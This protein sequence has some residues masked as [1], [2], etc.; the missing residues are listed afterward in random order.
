MATAVQ[1][2]VT[3]P[4]AMRNVVLNWAAFVFSVVVNF[5]ISPYIVHTLGNTAYGIWVLLASLVG[6]MG[7]LDLGV[8]GAVMRYVARHHA[9]SE[10]GEAGRV[11]SA[12]LVIFTA[13]GLLAL[14]ASAVIAVLIDRLFKI[15]ADIVTVARLVVLIGGVSVAASLIS[16]VFGGV[17]TALQRFDL[18][19][20]LS[21]AVGAV[22]ALGVVGALHAGWGLLG[23]AGVQLACTLLQAAGL[24][25]M[26]ARLYPEL[27]YRF[28]GL[29]KAVL[30]T[31]FSFSAYSSLLHVST[32]LMFSVDSVVIGAFL[33]LAMITFFS[34]GATLTDYARSLVSSISQTM[35]PRVSALEG[36]NAAAELEGVFR[37]AGA[38]ATLVTLPITIT[39][40]VRGA[41]FIGLWMGPSY[42]GPSGP[43][44]VI[45]SVALSFAAA[46]QVIVSAIMGVNRHRTLAP[47]YVAEGLINLGLSVYWAR[48]LGIQGVA[49][50]TAVPNLVTTFLVIPWLTRQVFG[51]RFRDLWA[52]MW[53][54]P[55]VAM[56]PF[57]A[58][59]Y[60]IERFWPAHGLVTFFAGVA[61]ALPAAAAGAW[62][63]GLESRTRSAYAASMRR[64]LS[65]VF[66][67][68]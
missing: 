20:I 22:R 11:A 41:S 47:F 43:V 29:G 52:G 21:I 15:P 23:L 36:L 4:R 60:A 49:L 68:A 35:T 3:Q 53:L 37:T 27:S 25:V 10:D 33:P 58:V 28:R 50:G 13:A 40:V 63:I 48:S 24:Y 32:A 46:R 67:R 5:F 31:I 16:G 30:V 14:L 66:N 65:V 38:A 44:L 17:V 57:T 9:R 18:A 51:T 61:A 56:L 34:I 45:L 19:G 26:A 7:L 8:R 6:Y 55:L 42:A 2:R 62:F 12:G 1:Y 64:T 39:F 54:R 59:T